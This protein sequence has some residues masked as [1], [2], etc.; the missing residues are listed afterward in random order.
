MQRQCRERVLLRREVRV[1]TQMRARVRNWVRGAGA[2]DARLLEWP[3]ALIVPE[4]VVRAAAAR[5]QRVT[6]AAAHPW[7][8]HPARS[9]ITGRSQSL[10]GCG[11][12]PERTNPFRR[13]SFYCERVGRILPEF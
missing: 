8:Y 12:R 9:H 10:L 6:A 5:R 13:G 2:V 7:E 1:R 4:A 3:A 11:R